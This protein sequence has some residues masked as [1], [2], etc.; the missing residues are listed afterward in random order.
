MGAAGVRLSLVP[1][2]APNPVA[3]RR[4]EHACVDVT[5]P[6]IALHLV[7]VRLLGFK[8]RPAV[9]DRLERGMGG[10]LLPCHP[11]IGSTAP[12]GV[13][14]EPHRHSERAMELATEEVAHRREASHGRRGAPLPRAF[15]VPL[16][17]L[18]AHLGD[19]DEPDVGEVRG[20]L[21][22]VRVI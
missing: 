4:S 3:D 13:V 9:V 17:V 18:C 16:P 19:G 7:V 15:E 10:D 8:L 12:P 20:G 14:D 1:D 6:L 11:G 5:G 2:H 21:L 22:E